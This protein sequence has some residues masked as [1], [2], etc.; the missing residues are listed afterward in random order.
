M[1]VRR[2]LVVFV[3]LFLLWAPAAQAWTWPVHGPVVQGF[4]YDKAHPYAAGQRRGIDIASTGGVPVVA[5]TSGTVTFAGSVPGSGVCVTIETVDGFSVTLTHLGSVSIQRGDAVEEGVVVGAVGAGAAPDLGGPYVHLG[6][7]VASDPNGYLDPLSLLP[8]ATAAVGPGSTPAPSPAPASQQSSAGSVPQAASAAATTTTIVPSGAAPASAPSAQ[9]SAPVEVPATDFASHAVVPSAKPAS[10][11]VSRVA[12]T[13]SASRSAKRQAAAATSPTARRAR[14]G[15]AGTRGR[16]TTQHEARDATRD[17]GTHVA[18]GAPRIAHPSVARSRRALDAAEGAEL[19]P[20][21]MAA[22]ALPTAVAAATP[23]TRPE[24]LAPVAFAGA[25]PALLLLL[26]GVAF[27]RR[28]VAPSAPPH[29][30][31]VVLTLPLAPRPA[32]FREQ[33]RRAA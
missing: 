8:P 2:S 33:D 27:R 24:S 7:R 14:V 30:E 6:I 29:E 1:V 5:P 17:A 19:R 10:S 11:Q 31:A 21:P 4:L 15:H 28:R 23:A 9:A 13:T 20:E 26:L 3:L 12:A 18:T 32:T 16:A 22:P 25:A